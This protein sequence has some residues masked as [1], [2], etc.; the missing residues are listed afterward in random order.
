M[1][2]IELYDFHALL[3]IQQKWRSRGMTRFMRLCTFLGNGGIIWFILIAA[4]WRGS[5][6]SLPRE[7]FS[8][9]SGRAEPDMLLI[10]V[11][12]RA[13]ITALWSLIMTSVLINLILKP[14]FHRVRPYDDHVCLVPLIRHPRDTSFPSGHAGASFACAV[15]FA[16]MLP[17]FFGTMALVL[18]GLISFSRMYL[19]VHYPSDVM[20]GAAI[21]TACAIV[22]LS[23]MGGML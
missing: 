14:A 8:F 4:L 18:A 2:K 17:G 21:G 19:G 16:C 15:V 11:S 10:P 7:M 12:R 22:S 23:L 13:A 1:G 20:V 5:V 6:S 9:L 3:W